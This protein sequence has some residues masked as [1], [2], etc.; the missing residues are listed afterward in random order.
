MSFIFK[1]QEILRYKY[2][3]YV[4]RD[5]VNVKS[6]FG[7]QAFLKKQE[8]KILKISADFK[9]KRGQPVQSMRFRE[10]VPLPVVRV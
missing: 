5:S 7:K 1:S 2:D 8:Y 10:A 9:K 4:R 6:N 3:G